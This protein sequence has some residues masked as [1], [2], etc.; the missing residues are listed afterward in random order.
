MTYEVLIHPQVANN[1]RKLPRPQ[2]EKIARLLNTLEFIAVPFKEFDIKKLKG[3][4]NRYRIRL[5]NFRLIYEI[6]KGKRII[7]ILKLDTRKKAYK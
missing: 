3:Q 5:G 1:I 6:I 4:D 2:Q 7:Q